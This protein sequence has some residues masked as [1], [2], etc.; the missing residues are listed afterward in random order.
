MNPDEM[1]EW[2]YKRAC[3]EYRDGTGCNH[4]ACPQAEEVSQFL[5]KA[6]R[7]ENQIIYSERVS[8]WFIPD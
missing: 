4:P 6:V 8:G 1:S 3:N 7:V 5:S 2:A